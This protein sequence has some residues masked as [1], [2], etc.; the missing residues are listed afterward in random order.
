MWKTEYTGYWNADMNFKYKRGQFLLD[1]RTGHIYII[2]EKKNDGQWA[3]AHSYLLK[4]VDMSWKK[5]WR[6]EH[7]ISDKMRVY[8]S[9]EDARMAKVLYTPYDNYK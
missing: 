5:I 2:A 8:N 7:E 6:R 4:D 9:K 1:L 3:H